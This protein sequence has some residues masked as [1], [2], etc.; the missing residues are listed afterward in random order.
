MNRRLRLILVI[1][2]ALVCAT[3]AS[4]AVL[5]ALKRVPPQASIVVAS[6]HVAMGTRLTESDVKLMRW[7]AR[8]PIPGAFSDVQ[9]VLGR[10]LL[11]GV[12]ENEPLTEAKL[13]APGA[14]AGL[15]PSIHPGMRAISVK[16]N[17]VIGVAGFVLPGSRVDVLVTLRQ[18]SDAASRIVVSDVEVLTAGTGFDPEKAKDGKPMPTSVVTLMVTPSDAER[19]ALASAQGQILLTLRN[20]LDKGQPPTPGVHTAS[21][22]GEPAAVRPP[23]PA[24]PVMTPERR[25][26]PAVQRAEPAPVRPYTVET[27]RAAKRTSEVVEGRIIR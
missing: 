9:K 1:V 6:R 20:P 24:D 16:V 23:E 4:V 17:E 21:L 13:A 5:L 7:P 18:Q 10:G 25:V 2:L 8:T 26:R 12:V 27:I 11:S 3:V 15:P 19:I 22:I 14:G